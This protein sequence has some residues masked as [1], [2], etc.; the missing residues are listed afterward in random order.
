MR[1]LK[2]SYEI[3]IVLILAVLLYLSSLY[4]YLLFHSIAEIFSVCIALAVFFITWNSKNLIKNNYLIVIGIAYLFIGILDFFHT[5][6]YKG[7]A[8]FTDYDYHAN[9]LWVAARYFESIVLMLSFILIRSKKQIR[10]Y[11]LIGIYS[12][13]T[14][15]VML[16]IFVWHIFPIAYIDGIGQTP[17]K[18]VSEY[19][20]IAILI[21]A[22]LMLRKNK[23]V[24]DKKV[25]RI[26]SF[27]ILCTIVSEFCFTTYVSNY[28][29]SNLLGH[30]FKIVAFYFIYRAIIQTGISEPYDLI[31]REIKQ[32]ERKL[33]E[34]NQ[35]LS[36]QAVSDK[37]TISG[38]I[39]MLE[40]QYQVL[41]RQSK[42]LEILDEAIFAR[43]LDGVIFYWNKGAELTFGFTAEEA[44]GQKSYDLLK[45]ESAIGFDD[46][47]LQLER[48][49]NWAGEFDAVTKDG[50]ILCIETKK[51]LYHDANKQGIVLEIGHD[52][53]QRKKME[54]DIRYQNNLLNAI[55]ENMHDAFFIYDRDG[56]VM[57]INTQAQ[58]MYSN[59]FNEP[60]TLE[61]VFKGYRIYDLERNELPLEQYPTR[62]AIRGE[63][64]RNERI[65]IEND[66]LSRYVEVNA[67]PIYEN[68]DEIAA[69]VVF[70]HDITELIKKQQ[71]IQEH[72]VQLQ[73]QNKVLNRQAKLLDLSKEAILAWYLD[74]TIIYWNHGAENMFG[75]GSDEAMGSQ[76]RKLLDSHFEIRYEEIED[77]LL[78]QGSWSG[79]VEHTNKDGN[80]LQIETRLQIIIN[81]FGLNTVLE[82]NRDVT[83]RIKAENIIRKN[84]IVL[85]NIINSTEDFIWSVD[86]DYNILL[87]NRSVEEFVK[88][89]Y[90][91]EFKPG[92]PFAEAFTKENAAI[93][94]DLFDRVKQTGAME[95]D[96]RNAI[97]SDRVVNY[98][99][100]PIF[101]DSKLVEITVFGRDITERIK[102]EQ[103]IIKMNTSLE[104]RIAERTEELKKT[105]ET[106][107]NFSMTVTHDL[108]LPLYEI[109]KYSNLIR[110]GIDIEANASK[111]MDKSVNM[112]KMISEL[113]DYEKVS[114][115]VIRKETVN[116]REMFESVFEAYK[117]PNTVL[118]FQTGL[119]AVKADK[120]MLRHV[121]EN[122][123]SNAS[124][125]S[126]QK[127]I[128]RIIVGCKK[129]GTEYIFY[130][131]D[132][133]VGIDMRHADKLFNLFER[134]NS[135]A[136]GHGIGLA[137]VRLIIEKHGGRTWI[138]GKMNYGATVYFT[139]PTAAD[140]DS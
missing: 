71:A 40:Q 36:D 27:S 44:I 98:S 2:R 105:V 132:N 5:I 32:A 65:I 14:T 75:Y 15:L 59:P 54:D 31:F 89:H 60:T 86:A 81:E 26:L 43:G 11:L 133:G 113:L 51:Q 97:E 72:I 19:I 28:G 33:Y 58:L 124:K 91:T 30:Y 17:F 140:E 13:I 84:A 63:S 85:T 1:W 24:F 48:D 74:G 129:V 93:F 57:T 117:T 78:K 114:G 115:T 79:I 87:S 134:Q 118:E 103:E 119:P 107:R 12:A 96:L 138:D 10:A 88:T 83:E 35:I 102:A 125:F 41:S 110:D 55:L 61:N 21:V 3:L 6:S 82:I 69:I 139:L 94:L 126:S 73:Q 122:L 130:V 68:N 70:H 50:R 42:M 22:I 135:D 111:I 77:I 18:I 39:N 80:T 127:D 128:S 9:Q 112:G 8:I 4:N 99:L 123:I 67:K 104:A 66:R 109:Q 90:G 34:Q 136:E 25:Y 49:G 23:E 64:V 53:T 29:F 121:V 62:R 108:K 16:S 56:N 100:H 137:S 52:I 45:I 37:L 120:N 47:N 76:R 101:I 7:M 116:L 131:K 46:M 20:I 38:Y 92:M 95:L 106:L